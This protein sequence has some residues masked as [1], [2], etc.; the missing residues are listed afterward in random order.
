MVQATI[1]AIDIM[2]GGGQSPNL[3][4]TLDEFYLASRVYLNLGRVN[5][6]I[7]WTNLKAWRN[8]HPP[9]TLGTRVVSRRLLV[10][11]QLVLTILGL[12]HSDTR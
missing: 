7:S 2:P 12:E 1:Q 10:L 4:L 11:L 9:L 8:R 6:S 3:V 5:I